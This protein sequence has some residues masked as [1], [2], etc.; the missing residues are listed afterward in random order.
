MNRR[1][2]GRGQYGQTTD[3]RNDIREFHWCVTDYRLIPAGSGNTPNWFGS[4]HSVLVMS[5]SGC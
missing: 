3:R 2:Y 5:C 4:Y 1:C